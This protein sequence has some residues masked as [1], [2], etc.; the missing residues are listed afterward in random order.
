M[1]IGARLQVRSYIASM[2][3]V[4]IV[5]GPSEASVRK[6]SAYLVVKFSR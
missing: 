2:K 1:K 5:T 6:I 3:R 4:I